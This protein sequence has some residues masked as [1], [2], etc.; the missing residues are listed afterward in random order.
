MSAEER[1]AASEK[2]YKNGLG[3][4]SVEERTA[5]SK[6]GIQ[7]KQML[8]SGST[9]EATYYAIDGADE[10]GKYI[11]ITETFGTNDQTFTKK[12]RRRNG[13]RTMMKF[14]TMESINEL[15]LKK[16]A[17]QSCTNKKKHEVQ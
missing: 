8:S 11:L 17:T 16:C 6:K 7:D 3:S 2:G 12:I 4:M 10:N 15:Q 1:M 14:H 9:E 13:K 5:A